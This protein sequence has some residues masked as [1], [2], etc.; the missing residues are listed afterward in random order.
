MVDACFLAEMTHG[1]RES[2]GQGCCRFAEVKVV[3][4]GWVKS[5]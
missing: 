3:F 5:D 4:S 1:N 2:F